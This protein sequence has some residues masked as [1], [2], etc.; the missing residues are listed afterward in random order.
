MFLQLLNICSSPMILL[1]SHL[2]SSTYIF[3]PRHSL[4]TLSFWSLPSQVRNAA[5]LSLLLVSLFPCS[6][7]CCCCLQVSSD[8][9]DEFK[10]MQTAQCFVSVVFFLLD[11]TMMIGAV[12]LSSGRL[13]KS[14]I[15]TTSSSAGQQTPRS[16]RSAGRNWH[17]SF[18]TIRVCVLVFEWQTNRKS[19]CLLKMETSCP[20]TKQ[21][22]L[23]KLYCQKQT[24]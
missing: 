8:D 20:V 2:T 19:L 21:Q 17:H 7:A 12:R 6:A 22:T 11:G 10:L 15:S 16:S 9:C 18:T 23:W 4:F 14:V 1:L 13:C 24:K 3:F 5:V